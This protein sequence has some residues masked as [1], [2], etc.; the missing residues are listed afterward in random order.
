MGVDFITPLDLE[1]L[2]DS[3]LGEL[4]LV[5][6]AREQCLCW[7]AKLQLILGRLL[8]KGTS[9]DRIIGLAPLLGRLR[10]P[11]REPLVR[12][13]P[14][15]IEGGWDAAISGGSSLREAYLRAVQEE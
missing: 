6:E 11:I 9:G 7:Q 5:F 3:A 8:P 4:I 14:A 12:D 10:P 15:E 13:W 1:R 2:P